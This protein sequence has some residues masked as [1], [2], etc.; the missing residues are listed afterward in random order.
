LGFVI[1]IQDL[2]TSALYQ[3]VRKTIERHALCPPGTRVLVGLSGGSDS[4]ALLFLLRELAENGN[5]T[6]TG[7]AHLNHRLR[8]CSDRDE[9]F[10]R[11][12]AARAGLRIVVQSE[13]VK[14]YAR[15]RN[16]SVEDAARRI[17]YDFMEQT[18]DAL[19]A[20]RIAVGHTQDDQAET[21][22]LKLIRGAGLTGLAGIHPRRGRIVRPLLDVSRADLRGYLAGRRQRWIDDETNDDLENPRNRIRH[23]VLPELDCAAKSATRPAIAR[24]AGLARDDAEW[25]D[26]LAMRRYVEL[27]DETPDGLAIE[28]AAL[29]AEPPPLRRRVLLRAMRAA[30][31][32]REVGFDHVD[33]AMA[34]LTAGGGGVDIPGARVELRRGKLVL[35]Q[36]KAAPK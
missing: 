4:V 35:I 34:A 3:R 32:G 25:L 13:D 2:M 26:E 28:T 16:L 12:L 15:R 30:A 7:V 21:F 17:R 31:G 20:D 22:L 1:G 11:D 10:C 23:V 9:A 36:Q 19:P 8:P 18:A 6:V 29:L 27:A 14:G 33:A 24:A 5:F